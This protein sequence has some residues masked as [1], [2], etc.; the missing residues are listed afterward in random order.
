M[1]AYRWVY[2]SHHPHAD[3][4]EPGSAPEPYTLGNRVQATFTFST[5]INKAI[6]DVGLCPGPVLSSGKSV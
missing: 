1:A 3:Y 5:L 4:Q 6:V 2:Y